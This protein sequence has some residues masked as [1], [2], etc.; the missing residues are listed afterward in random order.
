MVLLGEVEGGTHL[1]TRVH[2]HE[3]IIVVAVKTISL[4]KRVVAH[5]VTAR[6]GIGAYTVRNLSI[7]FGKTNS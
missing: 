4:D 1:H 6:H 2:G 3:L 7:G 5:G